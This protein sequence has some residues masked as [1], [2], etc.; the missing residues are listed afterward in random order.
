M[1]AKSLSWG[2][3]LSNMVHMPLELA[4][5]QKQKLTIQFNVKVITR[6]CSPPWCGRSSGF[7]CI[8]LIHCLTSCFLKR[9]IVSS[10]Q[11]ALHFGRL[12]NV[13]GSALVIWLL[14]LI[15]FGKFPAMSSWWHLI[16]CNPTR[17]TQCKKEQL[18]FKINSALPKDFWWKRL[19]IWIFIF[20]AAQTAREI[21]GLSIILNFH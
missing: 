9:G 3:Q 12:W 13:Q 18:L 5:Q 7:S 1:V 19:Q 10:N 11:R 17:L 20:F 14:P 16:T 15:P 2:G 6:Y 4:G 21:Y 8:R